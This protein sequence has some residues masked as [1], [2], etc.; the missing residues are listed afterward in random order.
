MSPKGYTKKKKPKSFAELV[1]SSGDGSEYQK[2]KVTKSGKRLGGFE[3]GGQCMSPKK[4]Y[5]NLIKP[6]EVQS[7]AYKPYKPLK[8]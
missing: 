4:Y 1:Y 8:L 6:K 7:D 2:D 3:K 5:R